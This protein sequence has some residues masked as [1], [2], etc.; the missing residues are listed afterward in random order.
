MRTGRQLLP[1][2]LKELPLIQHGA[3]AGQSTWAGKNNYYDQRAL[4]VPRQQRLTP[5]ILMG[6]ADAALA[7]ILYATHARLRGLLMRLG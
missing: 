4:R 2:R 3:V 5:Y 6:F 7:Q 1:S